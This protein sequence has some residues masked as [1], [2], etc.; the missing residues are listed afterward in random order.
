MTIK[1]ILTNY[2]LPL[3]ELRE[4]IDELTMEELDILSKEHRKEYVEIELFNRWE[5]PQGKHYTT[6]CD[7][8]G[9]RRWNEAHKK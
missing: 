3:E 5:Y 2:D 8:I 4:A 6:L 1:E 9:M 7:M